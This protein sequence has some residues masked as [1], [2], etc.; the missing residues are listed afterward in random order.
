MIVCVCRRVS[1]RAIREAVAT[2]AMTV[3][4]VGER[5]R[6]GTGCGGCRPVIERLILTAREERAGAP[7]Q[8]AALVPQPTLA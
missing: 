8:L 6:A 3:R 5:T 7:V 4:A 1:D 2:G